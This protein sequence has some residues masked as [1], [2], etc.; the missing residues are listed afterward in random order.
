MKTTSP[1][2]RRMLRGA[3]AIAAVALVLCVASEAWA[4]PNC[5]EAL[6]DSP[7]ARGLA[8]GFYYSILFMMSMPFL[9]LGTLG[10]VF[11]RSV[12]RAQNEQA[13]ASEAG[14]MH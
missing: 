12:R 8:S 2:M 10:T 7:Q 5:R 1:S 6:A 9:I 4:C 14:E 3:A 11:Y 13:A